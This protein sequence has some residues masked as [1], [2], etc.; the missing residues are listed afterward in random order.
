VD[1]D[2][3]DEISAFMSP[4]LS[5]SEPGPQQP[6]SKTI[7]SDFDDEG[8]DWDLPDAGTLFQLKPKTAPQP[9]YQK[10][11]TKRTI[12]SDSDE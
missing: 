11:R 4:K 3:E 6:S 12:F 7:D 1:L 5:D 2:S 10:R 8:S 9:Q